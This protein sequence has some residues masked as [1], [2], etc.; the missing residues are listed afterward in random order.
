MSLRK[1]SNAT[2]PDGSLPS[3][4]TLLQK[5]EQCLVLGKY[6]T[7]NRYALEAFVLHIQGCFFSGMGNPVNLWFEMGTIIRLSFRM[8]YHRDPDNLVGISPFQGEMRRRVWL[9]IFQVDALMSYQLGFPSMI[10]TE[11][12][13]CKVPR[14]LEY[15]DFRADA[16]ELPPSRP[17][18]EH[19]TV[20]YT[21]VKAEVMRVFKKI[22]EHTQ[23][24]SIPPYE[25]VGLLHSEM[26][27]AY[28]S[29]PDSLK[30][31]DVAKSGFLDQSSLI[32]QR[33]TIEMLHL[34]GLIILH[35]R[36][37]SYGLQSVEYDPSRRACIEAALDI[38]HRQADVYRACEPGGRLYDDRWMGAAIQ[39]HDFLLAAMVICLHLSVKMRFKRDN[40]LSGGKYDDSA[41][42][43]RQFEA[44]KVSKQIFEGAKSSPEA[45]KA[46]L[47]IG[48][49]IKRVA[50][51]RRLDKDDHNLID[52]FSEPQDSDTDPFSGSNSADHNLMM[53]VSLD[54]GL[55]YAD[56]LSH[57]MDGSEDIDWVSH[58]EP[59]HSTHE[60]YCC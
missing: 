41:L 3:V 23:S 12:C 40:L 51:S 36:F 19:T 58:Q 39:I 35:R 17:L 18:T 1:L 15:S 7:A 25:R 9:N 38:L 49:M 46:A 11:F 22:V 47:A 32:W 26:K 28:E 34:K 44:L 53:E 45:R 21:I 30:S 2:E 59:M 20:L 16:A 54:Q 50:S 57:M 56:S 43:Q 42:N 8:G 37:I 24:L 10:P 5:T 27:Q 60:L 29:V 55:P 4:S 13:D 48:L 14:N 52:R 33:C 31:R 6:A